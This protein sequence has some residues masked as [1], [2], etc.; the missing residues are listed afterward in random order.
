VPTKRIGFPFI[1]QSQIVILH[2]QAAV[3]LYDLACDVAGIV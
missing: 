3:N 2:C 1:R